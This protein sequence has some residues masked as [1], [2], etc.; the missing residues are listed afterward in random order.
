MAYLW[1]MIGLWNMNEHDMYGII[2][3]TQVSDLGAL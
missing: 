2:K 3:Q 1:I